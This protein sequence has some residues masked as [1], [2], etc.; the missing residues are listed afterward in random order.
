[1]AWNKIHFVPTNQVQKQMEFGVS[2]SLMPD[3]FG[4]H[5]SFIF[6]S[7]LEDNLY[8]KAGHMLAYL[9]VHTSGCGTQIISPL[10]YSMISGRDF[11]PGITDITDPNLRNVVQKVGIYVHMLKLLLAIYNLR[12]LK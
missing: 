2:R 4:D 11:S 3:K 7:A 9:S 12:F 5:R 6:I 1:M 10:L 8:F